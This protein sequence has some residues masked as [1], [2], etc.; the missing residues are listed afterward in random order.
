MSR[1]VGVEG[2]RVDYLPSLGY[3]IPWCVV[4]G[5]SET[6]LVGEH[7]KHNVSIAYLKLLR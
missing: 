3:K 6:L 1:G 7:L 5:L 4:L 2:S